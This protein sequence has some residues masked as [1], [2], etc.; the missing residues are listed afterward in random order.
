[1]STQV[2][3]KYTVK[4]IHTKSFI[5]AVNVCKAYIDSDIRK[6]M[7][8]TIFLFFAKD[9]SIYIG[10]KAIEERKFYYK[11]NKNL[12]EDS[13]KTIETSGFNFGGF[14]DPE[15]FLSLSKIISRFDEDFFNVSFGLRNNEL[16][17]ENE[18]G[19]KK[20]GIQLNHCFYEEGI[21]LS[22]IDFSFRKN[23]NIVLSSNS[24]DV[25]KYILLCDFYKASSTNKT[26]Y[27]HEIS[28]YLFLYKHYIY[29]SPYICAGNRAVLNFALFEDVFDMRLDSYAIPSDLLDYKPFAGTDTIDIYGYKIDD[30]IYYLLVA[31]EDAG[32]FYYINKT[33]INKYAQSIISILDSNCLHRDKSDFS[34]SYEHF[35]LLKPHISAF[36]VDFIEMDCGDNNLYIRPVFKNDYEGSNF[37]LHFP[38]L[39]LNSQEKF[40]LEAK[41][42]KGIIEFF[43]L[44]L[45]T[46]DDNKVDF[47][48]CKKEN[49]KVAIIS[50]NSKSFY[51]QIFSLVACANV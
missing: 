28:D 16:Y 29:N 50:L 36:T 15:T 22:F 21:E 9:G 40:I 7:G 47:T 23:E 49:A 41:T 43:E 24:L 3:Q 45:K 13:D 5:R 12:Y 26:Q 4:N 27:S 19:D 30:L 38:L 8:D 2:S 10:S 48:I 18:T 46:D 31:V 6:I 32:I 44:F 42:V 25:K 39:S 1:M 11:I 51:K 33:A 37:A 35:E 34:L 17:I 20:Y 14:L